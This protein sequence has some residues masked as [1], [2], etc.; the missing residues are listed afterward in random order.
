MIEIKDES[1]LTRLWID[2]KNYV[3]IKSVSKAVKFPIGEIITTYS[4]F[5]KI[6]GN[7]QMPYLLEVYIGNDLVATVKVK[8]IEINKDLSDKLFNHEKVKVKA[9]SF[10]IFGI[11]NLK[12]LKNLKKMIEDSEIEELEQELE[13]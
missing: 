11:P 1:L 3:L 4:D 8:S 9:G 2:K 13:Q 10:G 6:K 7:W 5:K 12:N